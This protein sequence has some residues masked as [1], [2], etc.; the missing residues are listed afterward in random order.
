MHIDLNADLGESFGNFVIGE[1]AAL[2]P[3]ITSANVAAGFHG[4]D[5][6][7]IRRT[8]R[9]AV[10]HGVR[11]GAHPSYPDLQGFGRREIRMSDWEVEDAVLYQIASVAGI[12]RAEG[13]TL[14][15]VKP[16]GAL[17]GVASRDPRIADAVA[18]AIAAFDASLV[19]FA[20]PGSALARA[21]ASAHLLVVRE[22]F[23]DR[24]YGADGALASRS[25]AGAVIEDADLAA[26]QAVSIVRHGTVVA[27]D[28]TAV[29][30]RVDTI[31]VHGDHPGAAARAAR[32]RAALEAAAVSVTAPRR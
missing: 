27:L 28:G 20:P 23:A 14:Q 5:P 10:S 9:L 12:A 22:G 11:I 29:A 21:G 7:V 31:C 25:A 2:M 17:Y 16:H 6:S 24:R 1:D 26:E 3:F 32:V 18:R 13:T 4:G 8:I 15:H 19:L 30:L